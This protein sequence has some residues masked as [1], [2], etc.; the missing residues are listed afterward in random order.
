MILIDNKKR[1]RYTI[2]M[3]NY[4]EERIESFEKSYDKI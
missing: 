4:H 2:D 1:Y 3:K